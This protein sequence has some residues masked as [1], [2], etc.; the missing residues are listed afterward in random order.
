MNGNTAEQ[1]GFTGRVALVTGGTSGIG[2]ATARQLLAEGAQVVITGRNDERLRRAAERLETVSDGGTRLLTI[3]A[4]AASLADT[5]RLV[6]LL[7][8]RYGRLDGVFA[9]AGVGVFK[10]VGQ[11]TEQD[12]DLLVDVN[13][14]GVFF[15][16]QQTVPLLEEA[17]GGGA[18][19]INASWT[20]HRAMEIAPVYAATKAAVH[21]LARSLSA[22]LAG[23]GI[24]VN[25]V[26]PGYIH[27]EMYDAIITDDARREA[28][29]VAPPLQR[30]GQAE[31]VAQAVV[32][33]LSDR[34]SY[35]TGQ[36][37]AVDGGLVMKV[38]S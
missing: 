17:S 12:V 15:T 4:D 18:V 8:K 1:N 24:R 13:F 21:N 23:R 25:S 35:I 9:N 30:V 36:D 7:R 34:A 14:K 27:T 22:G 26:S 11:T 32:F 10:P 5:E 37:L 29:R 20:L 28:T 33:L 2:L 19:V 3:R 38:P 16:V 31:D 6:T